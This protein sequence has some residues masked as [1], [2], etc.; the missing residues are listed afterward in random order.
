M[1]TI[2]NPLRRVALGM[3]FLFVAFGAT[4]LVPILISQSTGEDFSTTTALFTAGVG[5]LIFHLITKGRIPI[6]LGSSFAFIAP[7]I[8]SIN[9]YGYAGTLS[10]LIAVGVFYVIFSFLVRAFGLRVITRLFPPIVVGP[11]IM[12][13]G[14]SL[15]PVAVDMS[16]SDWV[17]ALITLATAIIVVMFGKGF[18]KLIPIFIA[19]LVGYIVAMLLGKVDYHVITQAPVL[20]A[21]RLVFPEFNWG[22]ILFMLPVAV[23]P[24]VEHVGDIYAVS[25]VAGKDFVKKPGLHKTIL[26]DGVATLVAACLGGPPNTTYSE[27]TG[28]VQLTKVTDPRVLRITA[29]TAIIFSFIGVVAAA[30]TTIP[31]AVLGG[32]MLLLFGMIASVGIKTL[33]S[34]KIDFDN[35]RNQVIASVI[36]VI[37]IGGAV[38][39]MHLPDAMTQWLAEQGIQMGNIKAEFSGIG[40]ASIVGVLLNLILPKRKESQLEN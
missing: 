22:A 17:L 4:V 2:K 5:T 35:T 29:I 31:Q 1:E 12:L 37:G 33:I 11:V 7:I 25:N 16:R 26:G 40:L 19:L 8:A 14:L 6:F 18:I 36:L 3:Q 39:P 34:N 23:A 21:P 38:L 13:I 10:G 15:A 28:A 20:E 24:L 9:A 27:V 32:V 30:L